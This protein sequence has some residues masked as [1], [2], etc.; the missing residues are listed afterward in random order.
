MNWYKKAQENEFWVGRDFVGPGFVKTNEM[1]DNLG[2]RDML[3]KAAAN[4]LFRSPRDYL[5]CS[6]Y[7]NYEI[8]CQEYYNGNGASLP[9]LLDPGS[10]QKYDAILSQ[11]VDFLYQKKMSGYL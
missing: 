1:M 9:E 3:T 11:A 4:S 6:L 10:I 7:P 8:K 2:M 5:F